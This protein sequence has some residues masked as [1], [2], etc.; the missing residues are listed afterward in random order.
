[1]KKLLILLTMVLLSNPSLAKEINPWQQKLP[2]K[3]AIIT[4]EISGMQTGSATLYLR[5]YGKTAAFFRN[6]TTT[7]L[8]MSTQENTLN[9]TTSDW[10]Y[11]IN[12]DEKT[13]MKQVNPEKYLIEEFEKLSTAEK[14]KVAANVEKFGLSFVAGMEG[15]FEK[16]AKKILGYNCDKVT[17]MGTTV[18]SISN[19]GLP[20]KTKSNM[21]GIKFEEQATEIKK[22]AVSADKFKVPDGIKISYTPDND[23]IARNHAKMIIQNLLE[24]K[25]PTPQMDSEQPAEHSDEQQA[26]AGLEEKMKSMMKMFGG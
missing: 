21:L 23:E 2:F 22:T 11:S 6:A 25:Q 20:L 3:E 4:Y 10:V 9:I 7:I 13:G 24:D 26:P 16:N 19:I 12:L 1:M 8:G 5:D 17:M 18:Y 14:K 15:Q